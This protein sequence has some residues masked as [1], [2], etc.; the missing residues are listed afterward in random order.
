MVTQSMSCSRFVCQPC[1]F[2]CAKSLLI[3][4]VCF[5]GKS[6]SSSVRG[7]IRDTYQ[8]ERTK[9]P[10]LLPAVA[11]VRV[12]PGVFNAGAD[13]AHTEAHTHSEVSV[14]MGP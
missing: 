12:G 8:V 3:L 5:S 14:W 11:A 1:A 13:V 6:Y 7:H 4:K 2:L 10:V 9:I